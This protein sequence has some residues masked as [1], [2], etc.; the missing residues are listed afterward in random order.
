MQTQIMVVVG[1]S[2]VALLSWTAS[3]GIETTLELAQRADGR[4]MSCTGDIAA[5]DDLLRVP[6]R[7]CITGD[8][9][10]SLA[11]R[12]AYERDLGAASRYAP[13][14]EALPTLDGGDGRPALRQLPRFWDP[15]RLET[16]A[17]GGQLAAKLKRDECKDVGEMRDRPGVN[18]HC[19]IIYLSITIYSSKFLLP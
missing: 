17:D 16:V 10:E 18:M 9:L 11:E 13:Y 6:L 4:Y 7:A 14:I 19:N 15:S 1:K 5:G 3:Q 12:L 2:S 8:T